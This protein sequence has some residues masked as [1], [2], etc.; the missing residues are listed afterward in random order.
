MRVGVFGAGAIGGLIAGRMAVAGC[1][2]TVFGRGARLAAIQANGLLIQDEERT[3]AASVRA[4]GDPDDAGPLDVVFVTTKAHGMFEAA[5]QIARFIGDAATVVTAINGVPYW[6]F[7]KSG[8]AHDGRVMRSVDPDGS[9]MRLVPPERVLGCVVYPAAEITPAGVIQHTYG[10][11]LPIGEPDGSRSDRVARISA[12]LIE[13]GFKAPVR[14][15]IRDDLWLK[16]LGNLAFNPLSLLTGA[17]LRRLATEP[18][19]RAAARSMMVEA[20][21]VGEALGVRFSVDLERRID[22]A[23]EV[24]EHRTSMLQ[25]YELGRP[26]ELDALLG[27]VVEMGEIVGHPMP[28]CR[29]VLA[30]TRERARRH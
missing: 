21:A 12:A 2:V 17:T 15:R 22:G 11:R 25:D 10:D 29:V 7:Y 8:G 14:P 5:P 23:G 1:E 27:A 19:L 26:I 28:L 20:Q 6:Y 24:G 9:L 3:M 18:G 30:L 16:L 4:I 13:A